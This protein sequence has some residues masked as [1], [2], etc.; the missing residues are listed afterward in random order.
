MKTIKIVAIAFAAA[1][2]FACLP[3]VSAAGDQDRNDVALFTGNYSVTIDQ[4]KESI[5]AFQNDTL[6]E[7]SYLSE[8]KTAFGTYYAFALERSIF[9]VNTESGAVG[10]AWFGENEPTSPCRIEINRNQAYEK[11]VEYAGQKSRVFST[12][13]WDL[14]DHLLAGPDEGACQYIFV[15]VEEIR[16]DTRTTL[17]PNTVQISVNPE[18]GAIFDYESM[19]SIPGDR[20][21]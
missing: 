15:F 18:T 21:T 13:T 19:K 14:R 12:K 10:T 5:R 1:C 20:S 16:S 7:P 8:E 4:A 2:L 3:G 17:L 6:L 9:L 11:A